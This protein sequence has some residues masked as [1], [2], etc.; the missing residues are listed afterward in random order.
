VSKGKRPKKPLSEKVLAP[1][2][3]N[4]PQVT[5]PEA[6]PAPSPRAGEGWGEGAGHGRWPGSRTQTEWITP[7]PALSRTGRG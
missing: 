7:L 4:K 5:T 6:F 2:P 1:I 3:L